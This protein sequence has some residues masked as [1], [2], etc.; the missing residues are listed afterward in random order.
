MRY[1]PLICLKLKSQKTLGSLKT[2]NPIHR[3]FVV[4]IYHFKVVIRYFG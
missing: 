3:H 4:L 2:A 1:K